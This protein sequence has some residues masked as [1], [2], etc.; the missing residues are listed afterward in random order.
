[1]EKPA[2]I[3]HLRLLVYELREEARKNPGLRPHLGSLVVNMVGPANLEC[4]GY[5]LEPGLSHQVKHHRVELLNGQLTRWPEETQIG[6]IPYE[7]EIC[8]QDWELI[9]AA[10]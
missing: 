4:L 1:M 5:Y 3:Q 10:S 2:W 7:S 8:E 6:V 9:W